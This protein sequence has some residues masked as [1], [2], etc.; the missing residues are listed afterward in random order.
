MVTPVKKVPIHLQSAQNR[1]LIKNGTVVNDDGSETVD[2]YIEDCR[3]K[4]LGNHLIIP[5][6][7]RVI[8]AT[9][10]YVLPGGIDANVHLE[11]PFLKVLSLGYKTLH[12]HVKSIMVMLSSR[13]IRGPSM[14]FTK[15]L[16]LLWLEGPR[17]LST[18][19]FPKKENLSSMLTT[20]GEDG[21]TRRFA[22]TSLSK[23]P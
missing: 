8:D 13:E 1:L 23:W 3:I 11:S 4:Q 5:G 2:V 20:N 9:G 10:K 16:R 21:R 14:I 7:T 6:G 17:R 15:E 18:A 12:C 22:A 19:L